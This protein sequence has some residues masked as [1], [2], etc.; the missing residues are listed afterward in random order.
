MNTK[1]QS[2]NNDRQLRRNRIT[3]LSSPQITCGVVVDWAQ[4][5]R[6]ALATQLPSQFEMS[7]PETNLCPSET[8]DL[9]RVTFHLGDIVHTGLTHTRS[10]IYTTFEN[11]KTQMMQFWVCTATD[12]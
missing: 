2:K 6:L 1:H 9:A 10:D 11:A 8:H 7:G 3:T 5:R 4:G 12:S